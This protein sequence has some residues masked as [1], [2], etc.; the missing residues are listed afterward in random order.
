[1]VPNDAPLGIVRYTVTAKDPQGRT[2]EYKP[3]DVETSQL[4]IVE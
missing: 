2:G 4:T 3:F 1:M